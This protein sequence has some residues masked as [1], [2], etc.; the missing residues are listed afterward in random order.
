MK[1]EEQ[2]IRQIIEFLDSPDQMDSPQAREFAGQYAA[3]CRELNT[4][5]EQCNEYLSKQMFV[6]AINFA[7]M[8]PA[9]MSYAESL[10][11]SRR[12]EWLELCLAYDWPHPPSLRTDIVDKL[13]RAYRESAGLKPLLD[14]YRKISRAGSEQDKILLLRKIINLDPDNSNWL[15]SL[16]E[17][18]KKYIDNLTDI[19]RQC[20][21]KSDFTQLKIVFKELNHPELRVKPEEKVIKKINQLLE[22]HLQKTLRE[23]ADRLLEKIADAYSSFNFQELKNLLTRWEHLRSERFTPNDNDSR[24][25]SE[26]RAW[27]DQQQRERD[28]EKQFN[29][30]LI[31]LE[32][33]LENNLPIDTLNNIYLKLNVFDKPV[34]ENITRIYLTR[35]E[36]AD[37]AAKRKHIAK[38]VLTVCCIAGVFVLVLLSILWHNREKSMRD[39]SDRLEQALTARNLVSAEKLFKELRLNDP[40]IAVNPRLLELESRFN[41]AQKEEAVKLERLKIIIAQA[42]SSIDNKYA[43]NLDVDVILTEANQLVIRDEDKLVLK[44]IIIKKEKIDR[45][46]QDKRDSTFKKAISEMEGLRKEINLCQADDNLDQHSKILYDYR[47]LYNKTKSMQRVSPQIYEEIDRIKTELKLLEG[48]YTETLKVQNQK[49]TMLAAMQQPDLSLEKYRDLLKEYVTNFPDNKTSQFKT[50]LKM[51]ICGVAVDKFKI[52]ESQDLTTAQA[53][54]FKR[55]LEPAKPEENIL[56]NDMSSYVNNFIKFRN[57]AKELKQTIEN[58]NANRRMAQMYGIVFEDH[59]KVV[60]EFY[61]DIQ[62]KWTRSRAMEEVIYKTGIKPLRSTMG[63]DVQEEYAIQ[64]TYN[65]DGRGPEKVEVKEIG[66]YTLLTPRN[67]TQLSPHSQFIHNLYEQRLECDAS[68]DEFCAK[69]VQELIRFKTMNPYLRLQF[70]QIFIKFLKDVDYNGGDKYTDISKK[71]DTCLRFFPQDYNWMQLSTTDRERL[72]K[73][74]NAVNAADVENMLKCSVF[75]RDLLALSLSRKLNYCGIFRNGN[76][77]SIPQNSEIWILNAVNGNWEFLVAGKVNESGIIKILPEYKTKLTEGVVLFRPSDNK[78]TD[79]FRNEYRNKAAEIRIKYNDIEWP[80]CWPE[81]MRK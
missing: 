27:L 14:K 37:L 48:N 81:N 7:E 70:I 53:E 18:E 44:T 2:L 5:L 12:D 9:V 33:A 54:E 75:K 47:E 35:K 43:D 25:V 58:I 57:N 30:I 16:L 66:G 31:E 29:D 19:A 56:R 68:A 11:F 17:F 39:W 80:S 69:Q 76:K 73:V 64:L 34:P 72:E 45:E 61:T 21:E 8:E 50:L 63:T 62:I 22:T 28:E 6:E 15:E 24:Q 13:N 60:K 52:F 40:G 71:I 78:T 65:M 79:D 59:R 41:A 46:L 23:R 3:L 51:V 49:K 10:D 77:Y 1:H 55:D 74:I 32:L 4:R 36:E 26:A 42:N 20:I 38:M 67:D